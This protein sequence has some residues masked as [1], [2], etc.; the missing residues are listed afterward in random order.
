MFHEIIR[1]LR[2]ESGLSQEKVARACDISMSQYCRLERG[3]QKPG[4]DCLIRLSECFHVSLDYLTE[5]T[6]IRENPNVSN[7]VQ[8][9]P[10]K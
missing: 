10:D 9:K 8:N 6:D 3:E 2:I 4:F 7:T 1:Q 5:R